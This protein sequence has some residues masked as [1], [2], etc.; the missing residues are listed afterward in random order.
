MKILHRKRKTASAINKTVISLKEQLNSLIIVGGDSLSFQQI[1]KTVQECLVQ[2]GKCLLED[3]LE[4]YN[5]DTPFVFYQQRRFHK[6]LESEKT[7]QSLLGPIQ[8]KRNLYR[9]KKHNETICPLDKLAGI[10]EGFW[11]PQAAKTALL[12]LSELP[13]E[14]TKTL[15]SQAGLMQP[16]SSSLDYLPKRI[17][18]QWETHR[19]HFEQGLREA[20][21]VPEQAVTLAVSLDGVMVPTRCNRIMGSDSR[22]EEASCG[23]LSL[24]DA[25]GECIWKR[26]YG[27]MPEHK[28]ATLKSQLNQDLAAIM[29]QRPDL[30]IVKIADG[31]KDNWNYFDT[32]LPTGVGILDFYHASEHLKRAFESAYGENHPQSIISYH[33][34]RT[35]LLNHPNGIG[36]VIRHLQGLVKK[37]PKKKVLRTE[38]D[39]FR[40]HRQHA[41]YHEY[42]S[43]NLPIGSGVVE[44]VCKTLVSQ[45]LK[46]SG[47][48]WDYEGGQAILTFRSLSHS[49]LFDSAWALLDKYYHGYVDAANDANYSLFSVA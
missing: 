31:A 2:A 22:Y 41:R 18:A 33:K 11:T 16:S 39:Y 12:F 30:T 28:K 27:R 6:V 49:N 40:K 44:A 42:A 8:V 15:L 3:V 37:H 21:K 29:E 46:C 4:M 9:N 36:R 5:I 10:V 24:Y 14:K 38:L 7:Y 32:I 19:Q 45:R 17:N 34:Y 35:H 20:I 47:M 23:T 48:R 43:Q 26:Q 1:E 25:L 13:S